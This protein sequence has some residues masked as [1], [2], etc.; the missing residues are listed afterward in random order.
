[1]RKSIVFHNSW[2]ELISNLPSEMAGELIKM[3]CAYSFTEDEPETSDQAVKAMF[4]MI[5]TRLDE[6]A[7]AYEEVIRKRSES[8]KKGMKSRWEN[9]DTITND[10]TVITNDN[11]V[12]TED[13]SVIK[14]ITKITDTDTVT[15]TV[16]KDIKKK[17]KKK[18][19]P[20]TYEEI[21]AYC[22]ERNSPVDPKTFFDY[23]ETGHWVDSKGKPVQNWKQK[24]ITWESHNKKPEVNNKVHFENERNYNIA[25]IETRLLAKGDRYG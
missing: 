11:T 13:N 5:K 17:S 14:V 24:L 21:K 20:P 4:A 10:N 6:D 23:F 9:K 7:E 22:Q 2:G 1:M 19:V 16:S 15:D 3:I 25:D 12:I 8:G 18:F